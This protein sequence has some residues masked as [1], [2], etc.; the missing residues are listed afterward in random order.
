MMRDEG[1]V[2]AREEEKVRKRPRKLR[3]R[4]EKKMKKKIR[5]SLW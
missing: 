5:Q 1:G 2:Y 3:R 4:E